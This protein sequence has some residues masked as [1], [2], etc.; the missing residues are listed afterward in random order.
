MSLLGGGDYD[1]D[2]VIIIWDP[3]IVNAFRSEPLGTDGLCQGDPPE[4]FIENNFDKSSLKM[5]EIISTTAG[6][7]DECAKILQRELLAPL[8][9]KS[10]EG[11]YSVM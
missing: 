7:P 1:G 11:H 6:K 9:H 3:T 8:V 4:D 5:S 2:T 10:I